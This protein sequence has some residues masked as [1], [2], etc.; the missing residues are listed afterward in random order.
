M[1]STTDVSN[2]TIRGQVQNKWSFTIEAISILNGGLQLQVTLPP[3]DADL[4]N[5][6]TD[7]GQSSIAIGMN[8]SDNA[9]HFASWLTQFNIRGPALALQS[10]LNNTAKFVFPG[11]GSMLYKNAIYNNEHD[12]M[13]EAH[14]NGWVPLSFRVAKSLLLHP[15]IR[16]N[17]WC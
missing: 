15:P 5:I 2:L 12:L 13:V 16:A 17:N 10:Q 4:W 7:G 8:L 9:S 1:Y 14:H 3:K 6:S 11:A